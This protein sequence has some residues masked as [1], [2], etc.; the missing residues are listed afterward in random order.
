MDISRNVNERNH[1]NVPPPPKGIVPH[2]TVKSA[3]RAIEFYKKAFSAQELFRHPHTDGRI[4]FASLKIG[5]ASLYL[6][7]D[8]PEFCEGK[9]SA[10]KDGMP[11]SCVLHQN[12]PDCD[13]A[14][15]RFADAGGTITMPAADQFW[16]DRY[17]VG[18]DPF[19]HTWSFATPIKK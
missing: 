8:F 9:S 10:P 16:G 2:L 15:K 18:R 4:M 7:D 14:M 13:A 11:I 3:E 1:V 17:G 6:H 12:V 5:D 19:G